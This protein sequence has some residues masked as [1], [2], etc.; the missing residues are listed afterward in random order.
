MT[1]ETPV[2][3]LNNEGQGPT[4]SSTDDGDFDLLDPY[5]KLPNGGLK[6]PLS[7]N[8]ETTTQQP[9]LEQKTSEARSNRDLIHK[10]RQSFYNTNGKIFD[11]FVGK[12]YSEIYD[13]YQEGIK[14][15]G[16]PKEIYGLPVTTTQTSPE[17]EKLRTLSNDAI[18]YVYLEKHPEKKKALEILEKERDTLE[19]SKLELE[20]ERERRKTKAKTGN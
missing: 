2:L 14:T 17:L 9:T 7:T 10:F 16:L 15:I 20:R 6:S 11:P 19:K 1:K 18:I 12:N 13:I 4:E 8:T 3:K 5:L